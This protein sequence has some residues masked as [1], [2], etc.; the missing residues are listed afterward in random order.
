MALDLDYRPEARD[1]GDEIRRLGDWHTIV[2]KRVTAVGTVVF[3][4][5]EIDGLTVFYRSGSW[6]AARP[7]PRGEG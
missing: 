5:D 6:V 7:V 4:L 2:R 1:V 3:D